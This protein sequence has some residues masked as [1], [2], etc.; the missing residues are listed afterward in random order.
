MI[1][2]FVRLFTVDVRH[3]Y[4]GGKCED[5]DFFVPNATDA[6]LRGGRTLVRASEGCWQLWCDVDAA[7][8][9]VIDLSGRAVW[10]GLRLNNKAF[11]IVTAPVLDASGPMPF[12]SNR[13]ST[14]ALDGPVGI[15]PVSGIY[16][17]VRR[18]SG[19]SAVLTVTDSAG[20]AIETRTISAE[21]TRHRFDFR[22]FT[23][24]EYRV[25]ETTADGQVLTTRLM[26]STE[27]RNA[28][29]WGLLE[30]RVDRAFYD[31]PPTFTLTFSAR[32]DRLKYYVVARDYSPSDRNQLS[33]TDVGFGEENRS[34]IEFERVAPEELVD[35]EFAS[36]LFEGGDGHSVILFRSSSE[37]ARRARGYRK[38]QLSRNGNLLVSD[39][40]LPSPENPRSHFI[41]HLTRPKL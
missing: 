26:V 27:L 35:D 22:R 20:A 18:S 14:A 31:A 5:F 9:P 6:I 15:H 30:I 10:L 25:L 8:D 16:E 28:D 37:V 32:S 34:Q 39:L 11:D 7:G 2:R 12:Y 4:Y 38:L 3:G 13:G 40:P 24:G 41:I 19:R 23:D 21:D 17:Y 1:R 29:L 33:V 36:S